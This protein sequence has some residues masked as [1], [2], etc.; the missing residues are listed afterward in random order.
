MRKKLF[1]IALALGSF[2]VAGRSQQEA[3]SAGTTS[4]VSS[5]AAW[6]PSQEVL[7]HVRQACQAFAFPKLGEC[8]VNQMQ[9]AG[10]SP[11]AI[12]FSRR[13][14]NEGYLQKFQETGRVDIAWVMYPFRAN[15]NSGCLLVNGTP[16][17]L[18]VDDLSQLPR[19]QLNA[20]EAW[21]ALL[22]KY[23]RGTL[24]P[25]DRSGATGVR[26]EPQS[27]G[28]Q[29]FIVDYRVL[30]GC[31]AC[32]RLGVVH[33]AFDFDAKDEFRSAL[34]LDVQ[35]RGRDDHVPLH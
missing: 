3:P 29:R 27:T 10:A 22:A 34:Y 20:D 35:E 2:V 15:E 21:K 23:P 9:S 12:A 4:R 30:D 24:W 11:E 5:R 6:Q 8:F 31:H 33:Y 26:A 14:H 17:Q 18:D 13:L 1:F 19:D 16:P 25:G 32:A 28:G 7:H